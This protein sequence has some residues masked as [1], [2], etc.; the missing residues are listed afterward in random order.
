M[1][2]ADLAEHKVYSDIAESID[3]IFHEMERGFFVNMGVETKRLVDAYNDIGVSG[4]WEI[5]EILD[6]QCNYQ[7]FEERIA[8]KR[9]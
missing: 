8:K 7:F 4:R 1:K 6:I 2:A 9:L 3:T 5:F